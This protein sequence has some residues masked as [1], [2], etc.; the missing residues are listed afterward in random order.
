MYVYNVD[1]T[2]NQQD[3]SQGNNNDDDDDDEDNENDAEEFTAPEVDVTHPT[4]AP[5]YAY[6]T[7]SY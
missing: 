7:F 3:E 2:S 5:R 4:V 1:A 6:T